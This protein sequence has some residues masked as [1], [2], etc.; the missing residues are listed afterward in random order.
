MSKVRWGDK[1]AGRGAELG[2]GRRGWTG[3]AGMVVWRVERGGLGVGLLGLGGVLVWIV[4][5]SSVYLR[6]RR[7]ELVW[8][9]ES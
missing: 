3:S 5:G 8:Q 6:E 2:E 4:A 7:R 1:S 9:T